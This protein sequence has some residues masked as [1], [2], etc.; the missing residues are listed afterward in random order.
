MKI[1]QKVLMVWGGI[2]LIGIVLFV[3]YTAYLITIGNNPSTNDVSKSDVRFVLNW[4]ELGDDRI[5]NVIK[6]Y[7]SARSLTGDHLDAYSIKI[8]H[9]SINELKH[10]RYGIGKWHRCDSL[11]NTLDDAVSFIGGF[12]NETPWFPEEGTLRTKDYYVYPVSIGYH[13]VSPYSAQLIFINPKDEI[14]YYIEAK[15]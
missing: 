6:S 9:V 10:T 15:M 14:V 4:C 8:S 5:D 12:Q 2:S 13:G 7:T 1:W 11:K 3:S